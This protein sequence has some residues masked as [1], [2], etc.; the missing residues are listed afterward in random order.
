[1]RKRLLTQM[2]EQYQQ[3]HNRL[4]EKIIMDPLA[5][6][7]LAIKQSLAPLCKGVPVLCWEPDAKKA[8]KGDDARY[9][10]VA[11]QNDRVVCFDLRA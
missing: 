3:R 8:T 6:T 9:L 7:A 5:A 1:M 4:P 2:V 10:G 11:V